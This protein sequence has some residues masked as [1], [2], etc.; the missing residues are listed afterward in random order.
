MCQ[1]TPC[2][3]TVLKDSNIFL[4][5]APIDQLQIVVSHL[6]NHINMLTAT[7]TCHQS[8]KITKSLQNTSNLQYTKFFQSKT[9]WEMSAKSLDA[10]KL[11]AT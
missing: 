4:K 11:F 7:L 1:E 10:T 5:G 2:L 8:G 9:T 3:S 6:V